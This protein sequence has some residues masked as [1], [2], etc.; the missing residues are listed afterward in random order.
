MRVNCKQ[1]NQQRWSFAL[2]KHGQ[3]GDIMADIIGETMGDTV[4]DIAIEPVEL[5]KRWQQQRHLL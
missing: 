5:K 1:A 3:W 2:S 4:G